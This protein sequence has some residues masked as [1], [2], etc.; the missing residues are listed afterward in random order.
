MR[1]DRRLRSDEGG[2]SPVPGAMGRLLSLVETRIGPENIDRVW[3]FPRLVKGRKE[4][5]LVAVS[6][7]EPDPTQRNL[8]T[9]R[10]SAE[11]TGAG[12]DFQPELA[13]QGVAPPD[14]MGRIMDGVVRR[15]DL[16][17]GTP[18]EVEIRGSPDR[19]QDL[20][21]DQDHQGSPEVGPEH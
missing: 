15:S 11:L 1:T 17:L 12:V 8:L 7:F 9:C 16:P 5:G 19:F 6:C 20:R 4:W 2:Q 18:R 21:R 13:S 14:R 10:Y 3:I